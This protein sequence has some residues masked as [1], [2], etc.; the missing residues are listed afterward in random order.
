ME[1]ALWD[2]ESV[3]CRRFTNE[4]VPFCPMLKALHAGVLAHAAIWGYFVGC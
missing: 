3:L 1:V 4:F 2:I